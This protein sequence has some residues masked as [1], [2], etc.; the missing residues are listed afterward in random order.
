MKRKDD[1]MKRF[2]WIVFFAMVSV[3]ATRAAFAVTDPNGFMGLK[4]SQSAGDCRK[5]GICSEQV[6]T[7][8]DKLANE[9]TLFGK[10]KTFNGIAATSSSFGFFDNKFYFGAAYFDPRIVSF[11]HLK[12]ELV[13]TH[14]QPKSS[15]AKTSTWLLGNTKATLYKGNSFY[16]VIYTHAPTFTK[17]AKVKGYP[18]REKPPA[19]GKKKK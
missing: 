2:V 16:G 1:G 9:S 3:L 6:L 4:W 15:S 11:D 10:E 14:G 13:K 17:V 8:P 18:I 7:L 5:Q 19:P 12:N